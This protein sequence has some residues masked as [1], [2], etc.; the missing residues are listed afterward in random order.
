ML[1]NTIKN[2]YLQANVK[3]MSRNKVK[4]R[5]LAYEQVISQMYVWKL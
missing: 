4:L 3:K 1:L 5:K 2:K